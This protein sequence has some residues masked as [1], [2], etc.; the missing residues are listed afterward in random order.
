MN[1]KVFFSWQSDSPSAIGRS[2]VTSTLVAA[3]A[4]LRVDAT[5][6]LRPELDSDTQQ[7]P[8]SPQ[9]FSAILEKLDKCAVMVADVSL[10]YKRS[11]DGGRL[12]PNPNVLVELGYALKRLGD[13]RVVLIMNTTYGR[14]EALPFDLRGHRVITYSAAETDEL[15]ENTKSEFTGSVEAAV[16]DIFA[17]VPLPDD[18]AP[19][20]TM[21]LGFRTNK[22][23]T[24]LHLYRLIAI[25]HNGSAALISNWS[26]EIRIPHILLVPNG[27]Y[28]IVQQPS[29]DRRAVMRYTDKQH[30]GAIYP[31]DKREVVGIDYRM[32]HAL[33]E[34]RARLYD[35][36]VEVSFFVDGVRRAREMRKVGDLVNF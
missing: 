28:P 11:A 32:T 7:V 34:Q 13:K 5:L 35:E 8:G 23:E 29:E 31:G 27:G 30:S 6:D 16:R 17:N 33:Y 14:P 2:F 3:L 24:D 4:R 21:T 36:L 12:A 20:V 15:S 1:V 19:P 18:I 26:V 25:V 9:I 10:T 22:A